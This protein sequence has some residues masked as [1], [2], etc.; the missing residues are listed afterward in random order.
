VC[1]GLTY[2]FAVWMSR[3]YSYEK[4]RKRFSEDR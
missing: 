2:L 3:L 1:L 4:V